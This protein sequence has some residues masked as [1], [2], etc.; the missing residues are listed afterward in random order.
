M[1]D[2]AGLS[3]VAFCHILNQWLDYL[4][5]MERCE[6]KVTVTGLI[7]ALL[8]PLMRFDKRKQG[9]HGLALSSDCL[10]AGLRSGDRLEPSDTLPDIGTFFSL[11]HFPILLTFWRPGEETL[12]HHR[13]PIW[14][15]S[16]GITPDSTLTVDSL[17]TLNLG[18][19]QQWSKFT[20]WHLLE[21][22]IY[23]SQAATTEDEQ[24]GIMNM[25]IAMDAFF[26]EHKK[27]NP[28]DKLT[29]PTDLTTKMFGSKSDPKVKLSGAETWAFLLFLVSAVQRHRA[30]IPNSARLL[31]GGSLLIRMQRIVQIKANDLGPSLLQD[32]VLASG[33][34]KFRM[35]LR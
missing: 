21:S 23:S 35:H 28:N 20:T 22:H 7:Y 9:S 31:E 17:H 5:A 12:V 2:P 18:L 33:S 1:F 14:D 13:N 4:I 3:P 27:T 25:R 10:P 16:L 26:K 29:E 6:V 30:R 8:K 34:L 24:V 19:F 11:E 32:C 15:P